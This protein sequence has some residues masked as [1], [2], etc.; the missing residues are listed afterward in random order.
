M[1]TDPHWASKQINTLAE[2]KGWPLFDDPQL[3]FVTP[4]LK[5][6][7]AVWDDKRAG[8]TMPSR[9]EMTLRDL[10]CALANIA[11]LD[12]CS[13]G[14]R[15]RFKVR[16]CGGALDAFLGGPATGRFLD[17][18]VP[19]DFSEKWAATWRPSISARTTARIV[20]RVEFPNRR[21]YVAE[22]FNAPLADDGEN[23][24]VFLTAT[25]F[26]SRDDLGA[27]ADIATQ[28]IAELGPLA[29]PPPEEATA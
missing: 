19:R 28:L 8:R 6:V 15:M 10:K 2:Q 21:Y 11:L 13:T 27:R 12:I 26:H 17:D 22:T 20:A 1:A 9:A 3:R 24:D 23:P 7:M 25:Y 4:Q 29:I 18:V 16:L 14:G 5:T